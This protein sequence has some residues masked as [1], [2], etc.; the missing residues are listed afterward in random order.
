MAR[1]FHVPAGSDRSGQRRPRPGVDNDVDARASRPG[2]GHRRRLPRAAPAAPG[3]R[4][5]PAAERAA[6]DRRLGGAALGLRGAAPPAA[7]ARPGRARR[8][9]PALDHHGRPPRELRA[10][11]RAGVSVE[12]IFPHLF[13]YHYDFPTD[14]ELA[15]AI[16][17]EADAAGL[18]TSALRD[19]GVRVDYATIGALH[20]AN[21]A[22]DIPVV[23]LSANNNPYYYSDAVAGGDGGARRGHRPGRRAHRAAGGAAGLELAVAPALGRRAGAARGHGGASTRSRTPSTP[24]TWRCCRPSGRARPRGCAT[25]IPEHIAATQAETKA[26]SLTWLL[27]AMGWPDDRR[28]RAGLRHGDRDRQR[29]RRVGGAVTRG[30]G[31]A[32]AGDA[33]AAGRRT[34]AE[35][36]GAGRGHP[37]GGRA[38]ARARRRTPCCCCPPSGSPCSATR[39]SATPGCAAP[40][41]TRT[42]TATTT[43]TCATT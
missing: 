20:L 9:R 2:S 22:W 21:P 1:V 11:T 8:A 33:A 28:R 10:A 30:R 41:P 23:S 6:L 40:A 17:E 13:R 34:G 5:E 43:A 31:G 24:G 32:G 12:P 26:G 19:D 35:L 7:P 25:A 4:G 14:V 15:E 42:G 39:C 18:V 37:G 16:V 38:A 36:G 3:L 29:G 27:A